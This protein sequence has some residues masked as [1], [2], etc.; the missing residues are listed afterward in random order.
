[1]LDIRSGRHYFNPTFIGHKGSTWLTSGSGIWPKMAMPHPQGHERG[2]REVL[3]HATMPPLPASSQRPARKPCWWATPW[4]GAQEHDSTIPVTIEDMAYHTACVACRHRCPG[5]GRHAVHG[6]CHHRRT[7]QCDQPVQ[8]G[9]QMVEGGTWLSDSI[10]ALVERG[11]PV[12][13]PDPIC[14]RLR[15]LSRRGAPP[16]A[17]R[18]FSRTQWRSRTPAPQSWCWCTLELAADISS[19]LEIPVIGMA[20]AGYRRPGAGSRSARSRRPWPL[21]GNCRPG[22]ARMPEGLCRRGQERRLSAA[23]ARYE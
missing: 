22:S 1:M 21:C 3:H 16:R 5:D 23:R 4:A 18:A 13:A 6:L 7:G 20:R 10:N 14:E 9:A 19:K 8:A 15:R 17:P 12:C 2:R 11:I